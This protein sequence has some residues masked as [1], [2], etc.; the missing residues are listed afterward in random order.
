MCSIAPD[1]D[2][3]LIEIYDPKFIQTVDSALEQ[4]GSVMLLADSFHNSR[5][6][7]SA[8]LWYAIGCG[9][10]VTVTPQILRT[11]LPTTREVA[12]LKEKIVSRN[13]VEEKGSH[14]K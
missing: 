2:R 10:L 5:E 4:N 11:P 12:N 1:E 7:L 9:V 6:L 13:G 14:K 3:A 8:Y